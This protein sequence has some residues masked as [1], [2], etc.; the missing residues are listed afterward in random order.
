M[1]EE[2]AKRNQAKAGADNLA[3]Y[4]GVFSS[5]K[6]DETRPL[7]VCEEVSKQFDVSEGSRTSDFSEGVPPLLTA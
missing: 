7:D 3:K 4:K 2:E 6:N 5:V 1:L